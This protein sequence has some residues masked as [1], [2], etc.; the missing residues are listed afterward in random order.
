M[1]QPNLRR[2]RILGSGE[3]RMVIADPLLRW[4]LM[5]PLLI[6]LILRGLFPLILER[7]GL[8]SIV[9][10]ERYPALAAYILAALGPMTAGMVI[11][12]LMLDQRDEGS[13]RAMRVTPLPMGLYLA[14]R[15]SWP[16]MAGA[17]TTLAAIPLAGD[18]GLRG[19]RAAVAV[20]AAAP[21]API[22][23]LSLASFAAN[24]VQGFALVKASS[25][26]MAAPLAALWLAPIWH[27]PLGLLPTYWIARSVWSLQTGAPGTTTALLV[28]W[29]YAAVL[30]L[31]LVRRFN[32]RAGEQ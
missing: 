18:L 24:K 2:L 11:G 25:V 19:W 10:D 1:I 12:F 7:M 16:L 14:Y 30:V 28:S 27:A 5:L 17:V 31:L 20:L 21:L 9:L 32:R 4:M 13:L 22:V 26:F 29:A 15:L 8:S 23:A 6:G 3:I